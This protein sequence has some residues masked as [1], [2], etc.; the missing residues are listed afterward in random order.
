MY[1]NPNANFLWIF[2]E[3][4]RQAPTFYGL[5]G[6][7]VNH[8]RCGRSACVVFRWCSSRSRCSCVCIVALR[9]SCRFM[10][11]LR[12]RVC[13]DLPA[14]C[15]H[16]IVLIVSHVKNSNFF[17]IV[18]TEMTVTISSILKWCAKNWNSAKPS[19]SGVK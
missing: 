13:E 7:A 5:I 1:V 11:W 14:R 6:G 12:C 19:W 8:N 17:Q 18:L 3:Q 15:S 10:W 16:I 2:K 9:M 4:K